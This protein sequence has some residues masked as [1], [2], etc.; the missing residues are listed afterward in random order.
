MGGPKEE[1]SDWRYRRPGEIYCR[2]KPLNIVDE[3]KL[4][5]LALASNTRTMEEEEEMVPERIVN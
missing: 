3:I 4:R 2:Y 5:R 1:K